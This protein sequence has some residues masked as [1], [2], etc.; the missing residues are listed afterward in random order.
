M[1]W[2]WTGDYWNLGAGAEVG[3]YETDNDTDAATDFYWVNPFN[4]LKADITLDYLYEDPGRKIDYPLK[5]SGHGDNWWVCV[6]NPEAQYP[7]V[8]DNV[9][10]TWKISFLG[11]GIDG[12]L[13]AHDGFLTW[14]KDSF[15]QNAL[16]IPPNRQELFKAFYLA[17]LDLFDD[18]EHMNANGLYFDGTD[19]FRLVF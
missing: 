11:S 18:E 5:G 12:H 3:I 8:L 17:M 1:L 15:L 10:V 13:F 14:A 4:I 16:S 7:A 2:A 6:F 19:D 9:D